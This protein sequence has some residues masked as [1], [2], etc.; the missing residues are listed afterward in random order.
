MFLHV[1]SHSASIISQCKA[2]EEGRREEMRRNIWE[3]NAARRL[4]REYEAPSRKGKG[5]DKSPRRGV[6]GEEGDDKWRKR[7]WKERSLVEGR[8]GGGQLFG[9]Y[10]MLFVKTR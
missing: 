1:L 2:R 3:K 7:S 6:G 10:P 9:K 4:G 8:R 5:D